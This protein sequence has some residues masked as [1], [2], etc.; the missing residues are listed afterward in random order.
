MQINDRYEFPLQ[1]DLDRDNGK[2][3]SPD[4]DRRVRNLYTLH[5]SDDEMFFCHLLVPLFSEQSMIYLTILFGYKWFLRFSSICGSINAS[6]SII[7]VKK[8]KTHTFYFCRNISNS[9]SNNCEIRFF[10]NLLYFCS[11]GWRIILLLHSS[12]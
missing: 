5:R 3:L 2:Y 12:F 10:L 6:T 9:N 11:L 7:C 8:S 1:L 4:A